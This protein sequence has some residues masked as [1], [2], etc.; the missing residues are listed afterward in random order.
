MEKARKTRHL[1]VDP[2]Q[3]DV[4]LIK[5]AGAIL[6]EGGLVAFPTETVYGLGANAL[7]ARAVT[8]IFEAKGRP[9]D[10]PLIVHIDSLRTLGRYVYKV[11][12]VV[13]RLASRFWPGPLTLVLRGGHVFHP[14]VTG[15]LDTV[16][17]RVPAHPVALELI[18]AA[19]VP[20]A[21]P[22][23]NVSGRPSPTTA[24]HVL[25]DLSGKI[26]LVL[27][28]GPSGL[29][30][31]STVLDIS[32]DCPVILRPGGTILRD[33]EEVLGPVE[34][35]PAVNASAVDGGCPRSPGMKYAHYAPRATLILF[36]GHDQRRVV[37]AV[38]AEARRFAAGGHKVGIF[39]Y[40]E[41]A[42]LYDGKGY[43]VIVAG[44]RS[45]PGTVAAL[46]YESLRRF[47]C[48]DVDVILAE[49]MTPDGL[50]MAVMNRLRR[51]S[52][53]HVVTI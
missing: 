27:D 19:G 23:A 3:P 33:L 21:A 24:A 52:G 34:V 42:S 36:D 48:L 35:D 25:E 18:R 14:V 16:A 8:G 6:R 43:S 51:A 38:L 10:N 2:R 49:G 40:S 5:E 4:A 47:D 50:G 29:G 22:S 32:G 30:V 9:A 45:E 28:G 39:T 31:E 44:Q 37:A 11:P 1:V 46:L 53:G 17:V 26:A 13:S 20:V 12:P 15:G 41:T 7:D